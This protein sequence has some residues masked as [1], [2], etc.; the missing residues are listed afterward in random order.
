MSYL[1]ITTSSNGPGLQ[2]TWVPVTQ[3]KINAN[4]DSI[5]KVF[6]GVLL[7]YEKRTD[8]FSVGYRLWMERERSADVASAH[9]EGGG[10]NPIHP[11]LFRGIL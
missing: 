10:V 9:S 7:K 3:R 11:L 1:S 5:I 6:F 2:L 4:I 8:D